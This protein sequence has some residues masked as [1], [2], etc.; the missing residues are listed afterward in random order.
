MGLVGEGVYGIWKAFI[1]LMLY[2]DYKVQW[3][4]GDVDEGEEEDEGLVHGLGWDYLLRFCAINEPDVGKESSIGN[5]SGDNEDI[6]DDDP[7]GEGG[8]ANS[9]TRAGG[10]GGDEEG[11]EGEEQGDKE[12]HTARN[13]LE[14]KND[15]NCK[16]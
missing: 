5:D 1:I 14:N 16:N 15:E 8:D 7:G 11:G 4:D 3:A 10:D 6:L 13:N 2:A 9:N 12:G